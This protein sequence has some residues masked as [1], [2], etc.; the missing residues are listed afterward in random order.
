MTK[1]E[2][3]VLSTDGLI[4]QEF[5]FDVFNM[6]F[7][8]QFYRSSGTTTIKALEEDWHWIPKQGGI[9][10]VSPSTPSTSLMWSNPSPPKKVRYLIR[11]HCQHCSI[12][13]WFFLMS[14]RKLGIFFNS[15][16]NVV[17]LVLIR[18]CFLF[19]VSILVTNLF[20]FITYMSTLN[21]SPIFLGNFKNVALK[22]YTKDLYYFIKCIYRYK[23][24][25]MISL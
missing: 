10:S 8:G 21:I 9:T 19:P 22:I 13:C 24:V 12:T 16:R 5:N 25:I 6:S 15:F 18:A 11:I 2:T 1:I 17:D 3:T 4:D 23:S 20:R 14:H 7:L